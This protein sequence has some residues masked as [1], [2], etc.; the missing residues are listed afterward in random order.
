MLLTVLRLLLVPV[1]LILLFLAAP[2]RAGFV[3]RDFL[4]LDRYRQ[5]ALGVFAIMAITDTLDGYLARKLNQVTRLGVFLDPVADKVLITFGLLLLVFPRFAPGGFGIPWPILWGVYQK[6]LCVVI[7]AL[8]VRHE[9]GTVAIN[10]NRFGKINTAFEVALVIGTLLVPEWLAI[11]PLFTAVFMKLL[12]HGT[13]LATA[14]AAMGYSIEGARQ[15]RAG[16][17]ERSQ[18]PAS[19]PSRV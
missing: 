4:A 18:S 5:A 1:F 17:A 19:S 11:G 2:P 10:A 15:L 3:P 6:D 9:L 14:A 8:V 12:W 7:G 16:R 13:V